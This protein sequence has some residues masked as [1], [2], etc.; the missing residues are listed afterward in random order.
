MTHDPRFGPNPRALHPMTGHE[1]VTFIANLDLPE[2]VSVGDYT[3]YDDPAGPRAF[4]D[5]ILYHFPFIGDRLVIGR[6]C[7]IAAGTRFLMN[8]GNHRM[9]GPSTYPFPIFGGGWIGRFPEEMDFPNRG[10]TV[11]GND[12]WFGMGATVMPGLRIGDGAVIATLSVVTQ[13]VPPYAI[14]AGNPARV[15]RTRLSETDAARM[16]AIAWWDWA[17]ERITRAIPAISGGDVDTLE[18]MARDG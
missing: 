6:F 16:Q 3:Y 9:T 4:L 14:V 1:R 15:V 11:V 2:N 17:P 8:G 7:A 13:D 5:A 10:D 12:V 18:A